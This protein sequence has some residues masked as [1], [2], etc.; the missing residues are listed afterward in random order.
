MISPSDKS[1]QETKLIKQGKAVMDPDFIPLA[2]W[3]DKTY[4][5]QTMNIIYDVIGDDKLPRLEIVFEKGWGVAAF[6]P[7]IGSIHK[8]AILRVFEAEV[9]ST[10]K[11]RTENMFVIFDSFASVAIEEAHG[12]ISTFQ[13]EQLQNALRIESLW[14]ISSSDGGGIITFFFYTDQQVQE[15]TGNGVKEMLADRYFQLLKSHD[16]FNYIKREYFD[17]SLDSKENLDRNYSG[18]LLYYYRH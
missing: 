18:S 15:N 9:N 4:N 1:Y 12:H 2:A 17:V 6:H 10:G 7:A 13:L 16:E 14:K 8:T 11:Y 5:V 3:I